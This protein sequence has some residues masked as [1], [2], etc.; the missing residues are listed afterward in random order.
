MGIK[1]GRVIK[2]NTIICN[3]GIFHIFLIIKLYWLSKTHALLRV[4]LLIKISIY[5]IILQKAY[6]FY[7]L[8]R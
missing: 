6:H 1:L 5:V 3:F 8:F 7:F 4:F 2:N